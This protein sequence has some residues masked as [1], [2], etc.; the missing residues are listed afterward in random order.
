[1]WRSL[2]CDALYPLIL[3]S[4]SAGRWGRVTFTSANSGRSVGRSPSSPRTHW[5]RR[6]SWHASTT[7]TDF[8]AVHRSV[9]SARH[10]ASYGLP[11]DW[12][13]CSLE[14]AVYRT[15]LAW[16]SIKSN[17]KVVCA[18]ISMPPCVCSGL[19][20]PLLYAGQCH[21]WTFT[22]PICSVGSVICTENE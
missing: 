18:R 3:P 5:W 4:T 14:Q 7:V 12:F 21:H 1:M 2:A 20:R 15:A 17:F 22:P 11:H 16:H 9:S 10:L 13:C 19:P 8:L 6:W